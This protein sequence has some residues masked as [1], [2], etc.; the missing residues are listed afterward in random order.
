[1]VQGSGC[2]AFLLEKLM[3]VQLVSHGCSCVHKTKRVYMGVFT[4]LILFLV[5]GTEK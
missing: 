3:V 2:D 4:F 5:I 1:M